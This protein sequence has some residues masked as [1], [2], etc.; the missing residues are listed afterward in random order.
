[1]SERKMRASAEEMKAARIDVAFRDYCAH[2]LIPLNECRHQT[3]YL[4]W[5]CGHERHEYEK[6]QYGE[7]LREVSRKSRGEE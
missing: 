4:P 7:H 2:L 1:M 6:C 5:K 3:A